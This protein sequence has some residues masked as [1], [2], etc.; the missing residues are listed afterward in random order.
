MRKFGSF[1]PKRLAINGV[2]T[3]LFF[4]LSLFSIEIGGVKITFDSLAVVIAALLFGPVDAFLVGFLGAT[5]E[6]LLHFGLSA[7]TILWILPP[8]CRGLA[9]GLGLKYLPSSKRLWV[10]YLI[11]A[12]AAVLTS[13]LN[14]LVYYVDAKLLGYYSY[15]LIFGVF[16][17]RLGTGVA[18]GLVTATAALPVIRALKKANITDGGTIQ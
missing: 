3:A 8:A 16:F 18:S 17:V 10:Y 11:C 2:L 7:T 14:T 15:A 5:L 9:I 13:C 1:S 6:Q 12:L 4:A